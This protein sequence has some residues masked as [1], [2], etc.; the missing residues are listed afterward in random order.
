MYAVLRIRGVY[1]GVVVRI[2]VSKG[3]FCAEIYVVSRKSGSTLCGNEVA[4]FDLADYVALFKRDLALGVV[5]ERFMSVVQTRI[6]NGYRDAA[7]VEAVLLHN[8]GRVVN[9]RAV[10][11]A[12]IGYDFVAVNRSGCGVGF[13]NSSHAYA[14]DLYDFCEL[15]SVYFDCHRVDYG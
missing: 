9:T 4:R 10:N 12:V 3:N 11:V 13:G 14:G 2:V 5:G 6:E 8:F 15:G 7:A 1:V